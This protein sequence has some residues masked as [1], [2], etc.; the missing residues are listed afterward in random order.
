MEG[1]PRFVGNLHHVGAAADVVGN[2]FPLQTFTTDDPEKVLD[3]LRKLLNN[4]ISGIN[5][6]VLF[7]R[8]HDRGDSLPESHVGQS[9]LDL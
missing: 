3:E 4:P 7:D 2:Q 1:I 6:I 5:K 8:I 9:P